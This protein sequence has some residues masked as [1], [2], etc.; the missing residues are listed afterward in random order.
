MTCVR[1]SAAALMALLAA[2]GGGSATPSGFY[3]DNGDQ[4]VMEHVLS[5]REK[6]EVE[7]EILH[8]LGL[9]AR[10]RGV[11]NLTS[12][13]PKF[14]L[15]VYQSLVEPTAARTEFNLSSQDL[16]AIDESDVIMSFASHSHHAGAARHERGKRLWF[17]V[18]EV[19]AGET[20]VGSELRLYQTASELGADVSFT[21]SLYQ[22]T[23]VS[24]GQKELQFVDA[25]N[26]SCDHEGWLQ[27]NVTGPFTAWVAFPETNLGLYLS[28]HLASRPGHELRP[29][30][31]GIAG[32]AREEQRQP[33][34]VAFLKAAAQRELHAR[35]VRDVGKRRRKADDSSLARN[36]L[37]EPNTHWSSRSC[38]LQNLYVNFRDLE[39]Q[40]WIIAPEGFHAFFCSGE[41]NFPLNS[42]MNATN[43]A[44][45]Q[46]LVHLM[47]PQQVPK[48]CCAPT[49][50]SSISVLYFLDEINVVLQKYKNM[51]VKS[52][53]CH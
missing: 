24:K 23:S 4:T 45:V 50:L 16:H 43:H 46:T 3:A 48:P 49:R 7:H 17:D 35:A 25:V 21:L 27:L 28:A 6:E 39:W 37:Y 41:C 22:L 52:C 34:V 12:S 33:F 26:S 20:I 9:Q 10:P 42:H 44:I 40:D 11:S 19:P 29:E 53:G 15:D 31:L 47:Y 36:P 1:W 32:D 51:V 38:Q 13:A 14:L 5:A 30:E 18:S 8:L 2:W